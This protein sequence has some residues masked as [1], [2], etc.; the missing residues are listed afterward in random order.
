M[1]IIIVYV[2]TMF[3]LRKEKYNGR[4]TE[5]T[6]EQIQPAS[7]KKKI[8]Q[9]AMDAFSVRQK[10]KSLHQLPQSNRKKKVSFGL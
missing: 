8:S 3:Y 4:E 10:G 1:F 2:K 7:Q 9:F 6:D 5:K